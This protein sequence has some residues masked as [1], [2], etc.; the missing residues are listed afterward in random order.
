MDKIEPYIDNDIENIEFHLTWKKFNEIDIIDPPFRMSLYYPFQRDKFY[1]V[2]NQYIGVGSTIIETSEHVEE[3]GIK[4][5]STRKLVCLGGKD[6]SLYIGFLDEKSPMGETVMNVTIYYSNSSKDKMVELKEKL[7]SIKIEDTIN[8]IVEDGSGEEKVFKIKLDD[9]VYFT[10]VPIDIKLNK[11]ETISEIY[12]KRVKKKSKKIYKNINDKPRGLHVLS[13]ERGSGKTNLI[14][15]LIPRIEKRVVYLPLTLFDSSIL[16]S[17]F[18]DYLKGNQDCVLFID[19]CENYFNKIHQKS[20]LYVSNVLQILES[21]EEINIH[22]I[23]SLN[24][25]VNSVDENLLLSKSCLTNVNLDKIEGEESKK[26]SKIMGFE[27]N[28]NKSTKV[29]P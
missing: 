11:W 22:I 15:T 9:N 24:L 21:I 28:V 23:L 29:Y 17:N 19:D 5:E 10:E 16:N 27:G 26:L 1:G 12:S 4:I 6:S 7:E 20:N 25:D 14:K 13:G 2:I 8:D 18:I 3:N